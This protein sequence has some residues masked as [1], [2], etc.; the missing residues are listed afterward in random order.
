MGKRSL[1]DVLHLRSRAPSL[2]DFR[3]RVAGEVLRLRP[4]TQIVRADGADLEIKW[5]NLPEPAEFTVADHYAKC[6][7]HPRRADD[8]VR[9]AASLISIGGDAPRPEWLTLLVVREDIHPDGR[10]ESPYLT[11]PIASG[12]NAQ[13]VIDAPSGYQF[14]SGVTLRETLGL[15][16][17]ALWSRATANTRERL[18]PDDNLHRDIPAGKASQIQGADGLMA[19]LV[20]FDDFWDAPA[21][22]AV[23][24]EVVALISP[25][26]IVV[27][28]L[29]D[30]TALSRMRE[31]IT[32]VPKGR[33]WITSDLIVRRDGRWEVLP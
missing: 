10:A 22:T 11:R 33:A 25:N 27:A 18:K 20:V 1:L 6:L 14:L 7:E 31:H 8:L 30:A 19:S 32:S 4:G 9:H 16:D 17:A 23:G 26:F 29:S 3:D 5:P 2:E 28:P 13:I 12:I 15:D 21:R 24:P